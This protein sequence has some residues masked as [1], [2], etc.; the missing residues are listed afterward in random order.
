M[1][2][3]DAQTSSHYR[4]FQIGLWKFFNTG[5]FISEAKVALLLAA[6]SLDVDSASD[7]YNS[8]LSM[9]FDKMI[10]FKTVRVHK[11]SSAPWFD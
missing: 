10:S 8:T 6:T 7:L 5:K 2:L 9:I 11:R 3:Q 1:Q 4:Q